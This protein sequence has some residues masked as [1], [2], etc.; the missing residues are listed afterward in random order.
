VWLADMRVNDKPIHIAAVKLFAIGTRGAAPDVLEACLDEARALRMV[1]HPNVVQFFTPLSDEAK[2]VMGL[3][4][5]DVDGPALA[6]KLREKPGGRLDPAQTI[7][8][9]IA[10][11]SALD[12]V[13]RVRLLHQDVKPDNIIISEHGA[14]AGTSYKLIDFGIAAARTL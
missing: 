13:H 9:G 2:G 4:M 6:K 3:A 1:Q 10:I 7:E 8:V 12:A 14:G 5:E 11:G